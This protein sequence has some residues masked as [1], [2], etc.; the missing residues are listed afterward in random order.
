MAKMDEAKIK[1]I[2]T[3]LFDYQ[4][5]LTQQILQRIW[6]RNI[7]YYMGEQ[8]FEWAKSEATFKRMLTNPHI[9]TPVSNIVRDYVRSMKALIINKDFTISIWPNSN[10]QDDREAAEMGENFLRLLE[11]DNDEEHLGL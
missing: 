3:S 10:D 6:F 4:K 1:E 11:S 9:P 8:W 7:L 5:N 2:I